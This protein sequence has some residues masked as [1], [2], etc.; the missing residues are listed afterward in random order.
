MHKGAVLHDCP[1][2]YVTFLC[3]PGKRKGRSN[4]HPFHIENS[5]SATLRSLL[6]FL[7]EQLA[8]DL[9]NNLISQRPDFVLGLGLNR[10]LYQDGLVL[11]HS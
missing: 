4:D 3:Q 6:R 2:F 5:T 1:F 8:D 11:R 10:M 9:I 7:G